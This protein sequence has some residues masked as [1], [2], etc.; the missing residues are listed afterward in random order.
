MNAQHWLLHG[1]QATL[2]T[3]A[4]T[5][6]RRHQLVTGKL[7]D[8]MSVSNSDLKTRGCGGLHTVFEQVRFTVLHSGAGPLRSLINQ[9]KLL[10]GCWR[11]LEAGDQSIARQKISLPGGMISYCSSALTKGEGYLVAISASKLGFRVYVSSVQSSSTNHSLIT[12]GINIQQAP[13]Y[14]M[15]LKHKIHP[16]V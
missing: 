1:G 8:A 5:P 10:R 2:Y 14:E 9:C 11:R 16:K 3:R 7:G 13:A 12:I 15:V 4:S 6:S